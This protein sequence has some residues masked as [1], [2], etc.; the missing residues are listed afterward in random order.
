MLGPGT[1]IITSSNALTIP[2]SR[3]IFTSQ[4]GGPSVSLVLR[5]PPQPNL[6]TV[7]SQI[8][9]NQ[10]NKPASAIRPNGPHAGNLLEYLLA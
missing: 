8:T 2:P 10:P 3:M 7:A 5:T 6:T 4:S 1:A 9:L